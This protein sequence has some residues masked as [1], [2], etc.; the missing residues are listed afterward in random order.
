VF[1]AQLQAAVMEG[2][3]ADK[4]GDGNGEE[5]VI[6]IGDGINGGGEGSMTEDDA[7]MDEGTEDVE[8]DA[9]DDEESM[10]GKEAEEDPIVGNGFVEEVA[11][12]LVGLRMR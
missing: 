7:N 3:D 10:E 6:D 11:E 5:D 8:D 9:E 12:E 1:E 2:E 4:T